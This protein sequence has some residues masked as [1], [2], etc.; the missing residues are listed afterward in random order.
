MEKDKNSHDK[1][2]LLK[3]FSDSETPWG[4]DAALFWK[5]PGND[6]LTMRYGKCDSGVM[7]R[8]VMLDGSPILK[9]RQRGAAETAAENFL[10]SGKCVE[11]HENEI[12][13]I[14][15]PETG[16]EYEGAA[17]FKKISGFLE[18]LETGLYI[19]TEFDHFPADLNG[20]FFWNFARE[21]NGYRHIGHQTSP[22][23][24]YPAFLYPAFSEAMF[25][26]ER[27]KHYREKISSG[28]RLTALAFYFDE[29]ASIL[30]DGHHR[31]AAS[32]MEG[33][34][35]SCT[36]VVPCSGYKFVNDIT[37]HLCFAGMAVPVDAA[38]PHMIDQSSISGERYKL[39]K[40]AVLKLDAIASSETLREGLIGDLKS[41]AGFFPPLDIVEGSDIIGDFSDE[42]I[43]V[44]IEGDGSEKMI[45]QDILFDTLAGF[46]D[47]R[48]FT[49]AKELAL[50]EKHSHIWEKVYR[51][52]SNFKNGEVEDIFVEFMV[53]DDGARPHL[54]KIVNDYFEEK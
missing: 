43:R 10:S 42:N 53:R 14:L 41:A 31:A 15:S 37:T 40:Y 23:A 52:L 1:I 8:F 22:M 9:W 34:K 27:V 30:L 16:F 38:R 36:T 11:M 49:I 17:S 7:R 54:A 25:R 13:N 35:L 26:E 2:V 3:I 32:F 19:L 48:T 24:A 4:K 6:R 18:M 5:G 28:A 45:L 39:D 46:S 50:S 21:N 44:I 33:A 29:Y 47:P 20:R 51:Y 12:L